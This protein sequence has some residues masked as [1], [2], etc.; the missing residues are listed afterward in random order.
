[1]AEPDHTARSSV[2]GGCYPAEPEVDPDVGGAPEPEGGVPEP[3]PLPMSGQF[4]VE[5]DP[6]LGLEPEVPPLELEEGVVAEVPDVELVPELPDALDVV[7]ASAASAPPA[8]RPDVNAPTARALRRR[9]CMVC[10]ALL[11]LWCARSV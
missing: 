1:M 7:A 9:I 2:A 11:C 8:R 4:L 5:P 6:E 10:S 3:D